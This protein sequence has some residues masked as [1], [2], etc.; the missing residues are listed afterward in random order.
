M[1]LAGFGELFVS[2]SEDG[3]GPVEVSYVV[4]FDGFA[5]V[6]GDGSAVL[7]EEGVGVVG[8]GLAAEHAVAGDGDYCA[9]VEEGGGEVLAAVDAARVEGDDAVGFEAG[10]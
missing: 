3:F 2:V 9:V 8:V 10:H 6:G 1:G 5:L 4:D 7:A